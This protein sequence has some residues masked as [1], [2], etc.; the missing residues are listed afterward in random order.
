VLKSIKII[1]LLIC[2]QI[3]L[4]A[5]NATHT[6]TK[7]KLDNTRSLKRNM[8]SPNTKVSDHNY[9][10]D[11][12]DKFLFS[13]YAKHTIESPYP[14]ALID[15][16][17]PDNKV[18]VEKESLF[19]LCGYTIERTKYHKERA[20]YIAFYD[21]G[22]SPD[23]QSFDIAHTRATN[24][25]EKAHKVRQNSFSC[26]NT[27][28]IAE[29]ELLRS[30]QFGARGIKRTAENVEITVHK[31]KPIITRPLLAKFLEKYRAFENNK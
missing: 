26:D 5:M 23:L 29:Q 30:L 13:N 14:T 28:T 22:L 2:L 6:S 16:I 31:Q 10:F 1:L 21:I 24:T 9:Q 11:A 3:P 7:T 17:S 27:V 19:K 18:T 4:A 15:A 25:N 12:A 20:L 8:K